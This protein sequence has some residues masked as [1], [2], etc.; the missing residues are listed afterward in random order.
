MRPPVTLISPF[1]RPAGGNLSQ[2]ARLV[3]VPFLGS[4]ASSGVPV[5]VP[6][7]V[8]GGGDL[9]A[10]LQNGRVASRQDRPAD[11]DMA[12]HELELFI[13]QLARLEQDA[14]GNADLADVV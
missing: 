2:M 11:L 1:E 10:H 6:P 12:L 14:I 4:R 5:A 9:G 8:V 13:G 3:A 7:F